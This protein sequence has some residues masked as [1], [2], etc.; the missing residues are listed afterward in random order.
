MSTPA[1]KRRRIDASNT[2]SKP[3]R[4]P[5]RTP[6]KT[7]FLST[8]TSESIKT[9]NKVP[10]EA[11][12][13]PSTPSSAVSPRLS[14]PAS[15]TTPLFPRRSKKRTFLSTP[16][17]N[18]NADPDIAPLLKQQKEL[19]KELRELKEE[20]DRAEQA[21][22]IECES[23][24]YENVLEDGPQKD[25]VI[26]AELRN[27]VVKWRNASRSAAEEMFGGARDRVNR[28]GGPRAWKDMQKRQQEFQNSWNEEGADNKNNESSSDEDGVERPAIEKRDLYAE[29]DVDPETENEK[30]LR[31]DT[32]ED[33]G[34]EDEFTMAMML[35]TLNVDLK[36][37]GYSREEQRWS[38]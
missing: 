24:K 8:T 25:F 4:S 34:Q 15:S 19:E 18:L 33:P 31:T 23:R 36:I 1:A 10:L 28:M 29:Y 38:D 14:N 11:P 35:K 2:L 6:F 32:G 26:D 30:A 5:F 13:N 9:Q 20:L 3:F 22:K 12:S 37:I 16:N 7:P 21:R 17:T 27:L